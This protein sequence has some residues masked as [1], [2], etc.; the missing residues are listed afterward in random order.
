M[1]AV[2]GGE[3]H[4]F[5]PAIDLYKAAG[6]A[7]GFAESELKVGL[8]SIGYVGN[9]KEQAVADFFPSY[10]AMFDK[11]GKERGFPP[12]SRAGFEAQNGPTGALLVGEPQEIAD[13]ILRHSE[14]LGG[15]ERV[16]FQMD[17]VTNH[18]QLMQSIELIGD[19][20]LPLLK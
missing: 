11:I 17:A 10:K 12:V 4:R 9:T 3:T 7:A 18:Q 6:K 19:K 13:K 14:A 8:H 16:T 1:V 20:I 5:K 15:L 2:I